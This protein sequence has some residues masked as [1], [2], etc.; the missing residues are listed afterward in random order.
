MIYRYFWSK[1]VKSKIGIQFRIP[2]FNIHFLLKQ[3]L[4][5]NFLLIACSS[6]YGQTDAAVL[7]NTVV[8]KITD[9]TQNIAETEKRKSITNYN[10]HAAILAQN[11]KFVE[12]YS[13]IQQTNSFLNEGFDYVAAD[14]VIV[15]ISAWKKT[16]TDGVITNKDQFQTSRNLT[17]TSLLLHELFVRTER[18]IKSINSYHT[19]LALYQHKLDSLAKDSILYELPKD[20]IYV[21]SYLT[22]LMDLKKILGPMNAK[23]KSELD[24]IQRVEL[25]INI[26]KSS[27]E[28][29]YAQTEM[30]RKQMDRGVL[31]KKFA[32]V[33]PPNLK[34]ITFSQL[35][36]Y[37]FTKAELLVLFYTANHLSIL[38]LMIF[39]FLIVVIYLRIVVKKS[40]KANLFASLSQH[41]QIIRHP[42]S[43]A[44]LISI[45]I[46]QFFLPLPPFIVTSFLWFLSAIS[47]AIILRKAIERFW[48]Y[49][50][51][52]FFVLFVLALFHNFILPQSTVERTLIAVVSVIGLLS[53]IGFMALNKSSML[54]DRAISSLLVIII[55]FQLASIYF[56]INANFNLAKSFMTNGFFTFIVAFMVYWSLSLGRDIL[57][58]SKFFHER[59]E[60]ERLEIPTQAMNA[61]FPLY[62]YVIIF[63]AWLVLLSR[64][65]HT[66]QS[67]IE[68]LQ[69]AF[70]ETR[71][72]GEFEFTYQSVFIFIIVIFL[73]TL[74]SKIVSF[75]STNVTPTILA[76]NEK[77]P[78]SWLLLIR[79]AII[80]LGILLAFTAAGIPMDRLS[81]IIGALGVGIGFGLQT[82]VNNLVS[83]L[84]IA[85]EKPINVGDIVEISGQEGRMKS[86][87]IRSSVVTTWN[88]ADV[89]IPNGDL[90]SQH[91]INWT[92]GSDKRRFEI[93]LGVAYGSDLEKVKKLLHDLM[94]N[95]KRILRYPEPITIVT[96]FNNSSID[97][98]LKFWV[99]HFSIGN[100]VKSDLLLAIDS[101][102][103]ENGIVI[104]FPQQDVYLHESSKNEVTEAPILD[105]NS[106]KK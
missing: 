53:A 63:F 55:L 38:L 79:I 22:K 32:S 92:M 75:L 48:Y 9:Y 5:L 7:R 103:K 94:Q 56:N 20:S 1:R 51:L 12:L 65:S 61:R 23:L 85:F 86:I 44:L 24:S 58:I 95:E 73:S 18:W 31:K 69:T 97:Y 46:F 29:E 104:P 70:H 35:I 68:P 30:L 2:G 64:N 14:F 81:V 93:S 11:Q 52:V 62:F 98:V 89:I 77:G 102:F 26:L 34:Y 15:Q 84:I 50:Y 3:F 82:L 59:V 37:S 25:K 87:G 36:K 33:N 17:A 106:E 80:S 42:I 66:Y 45:T 88:G 28:A 47:M 57:I 27:L 49:A 6:G 83:G 105:D 90:M 71:S 101:L 10:N 41:T 60:D 99:P 16:A 96:Q 78:G 21:A 67:M 43:S 72:I 4:V 19:S 74:I 91:L 100:D 54:K 39:L 13:E 40:K 76:T 8:G